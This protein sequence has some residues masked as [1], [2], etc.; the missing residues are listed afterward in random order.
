M[1]FSAQGNSPNN[2]SLSDATNNALMLEGQ[3]TPVSLDDQLD[4][5]SASF[6]DRLIEHQNG[7]ATSP[8]SDLEASSLIKLDNGDVL[9]MREVNR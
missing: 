8:S 7:E 2:L 9:Y 3:Q 5:D 1:K 4:P 6:E